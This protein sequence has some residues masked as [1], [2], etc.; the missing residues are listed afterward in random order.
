MRKIVTALFNDIKIWFVPFFLFVFT[1]FYLNAL[2]LYEPPQRERI[3]KRL[4]YSLQR[5]KETDE[6]NIWVFFTDKGIFSMD[7]YE[8]RIIQFKN[9]LS[10]RRR[11]RRE[12]TG[13]AKI[14]DFTD[15]PVHKDY[16]YKI[17]EKGIKRRII[18]NW[19]NG[20]SFRVRKKEIEE[21]KYFPFVRKIERV[22]KFYLKPETY[23]PQKKVIKKMDKEEG[24]EF[25]YGSS[26]SQ[27]SLIA[28]DI[29]HN[30]G[31]F[32]EGIRI[33]LFDT[34]FLVDST[35]FEALGVVSKRIIDQWDFI[36]NDSNVGWEY[37]DPP[38]QYDHGTSMLSLIAG[39]K[40]N[41]LIGPAFNAEFAL[42]KT[43]MVDQEIMQEEDH[44]AAAA[45]WADTCGSDK[46]GV[47]IISSSLG[48]KS[49]DD[50]IGYSYADMNG[51]TT[52]ITRAADMAVS[53]GIVV[54]TAMGN[55]PSYKPTDRP[56]TCIVAP[57]DG[58]SVI[59]AG[60]VDSNVVTGKWEWAWV[61]EKGTGAIIGPTYDGR[62]KPEVCASWNGY[63][64]NPE[65]D[66]DLPDT[67][68]RPPYITGQG[69]SESTALIAGGCALILQ[70]H[71]NWPPMKL[72]E[73]LIN[74]ARQHNSPDDTLGWG[75]ANIW[76]A[77]NYETPIIP[78][79][80]DD[81]LS[82]P[83]PNPFNPK[84]HYTVVFPYNIMNQGISGKIFIYSLSGKKIK[85]I[86]LGDG[87]LLPGR[88]LTPEDGVPTWN[89][90]DENGKIVDAGIYIIL[91][92]TGYTSSI[93]KLAII[94]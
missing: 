53:K 68:Q 27:N 1:T 28:I 64:I 60:A 77:I 8:K 87:N 67:A 66:P 78:S 94:R 57:A 45:E 36:N 41:E 12:K 18:S 20:A 62:I 89:G 54:V 74:T 50:T 42:A 48:Y 90:K 58:D 29:A 65:Y 75:I 23:K 88:Y 91:L 39:F 56:D 43:E 37:G 31:Y 4:Q 52:I 13:R 21:I 40:D 2:E 59:S 83:Y 85:E 71:P 16:I 47:D 81:E 3:G 93:K 79:F 10:P 6:I 17:E 7:E 72:K 44:W 25:N 46:G 5:M 22:E 51:N 82:P 80:V 30:N 73:A 38:G 26:K 24:F 35:R 70:A 14:V 15:L 86:E 92:R 33:G 32:G 34:G 84:K 61:P 63:H 11:K 49:F 55:V 19:L 9:S 69:T 76:G